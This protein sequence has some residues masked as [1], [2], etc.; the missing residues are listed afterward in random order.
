MLG[1]LLCRATPARGKD[2]SVRYLRAAIGSI[3]DRAPLSFV[4]EYSAA[5]GLTEV[6]HSYLR[7]K[8]FSRFTVRDPE[9]GFTFD[10]VYCQKN[11]AVFRTLIELQEDTLYRFQGY[12]EQGEERADA[13]F[14]TSIE[15]VRSREAESL[16][17]AET[18]GPK[19]YRLVLTDHIT[20]NR[21]V[22][23]NIELGKRY[24]LM[25][26]TVV[27]EEEPPARPGTQVLGPDR[28]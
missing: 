14:V 25:G 21:T 19:T 18:A 27:V 20:S 9:S 15:P 17:A 13:V 4:A 5:D 2:V 28:Y 11:A 24:N 1:L 26:T 23:V 7:G 3:R 8:G 6:R 10:Q 12:K 16:R 22:L